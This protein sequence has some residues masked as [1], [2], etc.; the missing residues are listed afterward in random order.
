MS[1][2]CF[3]GNQDK[4]LKFIRKTVLKR[5]DK[6]LNVVTNMGELTVFMKSPYFTYL[7]DMMRDFNPFY[8]AM[9]LALPFSPLCDDDPVYKD[10]LILRLDKPFFDI[11]LETDFLDF[12]ALSR[13]LCWDVIFV[14]DNIDDLSHKMV[15]LLIDFSVSFDN[16]FSFTPSRIKCGLG[17]FTYAYS[18]SI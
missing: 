17:D 12:L 1:I 14:I 8:S 16:T 5:L 15:K 4:K 18:Y 7:P 9:G 10:L 13:R 3:S 2:Y 11:G 6:N